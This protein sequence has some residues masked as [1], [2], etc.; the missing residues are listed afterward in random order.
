MIV[1]GQ[2]MNR[3]HYGPYHS[4][5][6]EEDISLP[7]VQ[8]VI[9]GESEAMAFD[10]C[11]GPLPEAF[12][13]CDV[14]YGEPPWPLGIKV[15]NKR[16]GAS[17]TFVDIYNALARLV[18]S[19]SVPVYLLISPYHKKLL[20]K[21]EETLVVELDIHGTAPVDV[22]VYRPEVDVR[23][24]RTRTDLI[25]ALARHHRRVGDFF[26]GYGETGRLFAQAGKSFVLSDL[27]PR[28]IGYLQRVAQTWRAA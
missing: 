21:P 13:T 28:C 10:L 4:A 14:L 2:R 22:F 16:A 20:P 3:K 7:S 5:C 23:P 26:C 19:T 9:L 24:V 15:F 27:N 8:H 6:W 11:S 18:L 25:K 12:K 17:G 1:E